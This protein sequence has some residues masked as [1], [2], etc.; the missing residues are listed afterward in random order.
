MEGVRRVPARSYDFL[1]AERTKNLQVDGCRKDTDPTLRVLD[2][3]VKAISPR[4][5]TLEEE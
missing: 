1:Q 5:Y 3:E 4:K 2:V